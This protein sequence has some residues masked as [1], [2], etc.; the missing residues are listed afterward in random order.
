MILLL[1]LYASC[2]SNPD[3]LSNYKSAS[4]VVLAFIDLKDNWQVL[5]MRMS[6]WMSVV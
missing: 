4:T 1:K 2:G 3:G 5:H 6:E